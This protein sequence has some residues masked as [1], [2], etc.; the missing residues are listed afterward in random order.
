MNASQNT[1]PRIGYWSA[2]SL[3]G[4]CKHINNV[5]DMHLCLDGWIEKLLISRQQL[6]DKGS[7]Q[8]AGL[9]DQTSHTGFP[10]I[11]ISDQSF[12]L[13]PSWTQSNFQIQELPTESLCF[14]LAAQ[15][16]VSEQMCHCPMW[17]WKL[18]SQFI[19]IT[20]PTQSAFWVKTY[21]HRELVAPVCPVDRIP[22]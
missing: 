15:R 17:L 1:W 14:D 13:L 3:K 4:H 21:I 10:L 9:H 18:S 7:S 8:W 5:S 19:Q 2:N 11:I 22:S 6:W 20:Q 12:W 16:H